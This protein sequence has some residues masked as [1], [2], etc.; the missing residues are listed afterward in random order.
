MDRVCLIDCLSHCPVDGRETWDR[1]SLTRTPN[2]HDSSLHPPGR[3]G[4]S[5]SSSSRIVSIHRATEHMAVLAF[6]RQ[7]IQSD[8]FI[9]SFK[10]GEWTQDMSTSPTISRRT[11]GRELQLPIKVLFILDLVVRKKEEK[12]RRRRG[13]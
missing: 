1:W 5:S 11:R 9:L 13:E 6:S 12:K 10:G 3:S 2:T 8:V 7:H 4:S